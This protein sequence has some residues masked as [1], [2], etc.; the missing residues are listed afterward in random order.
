V[1]PETVYA[2]YSNKGGLL[3]A[4]V[5]GAVLRDDEPEK[6]LERR[7]VRRLL[8]QPDLRARLRSLVRHTAGTL[9]RTSPLC[10]VIRE[11][12][13][14]SSELADLNERLRELRFGGQAEIIAAI[15]KDDSLRPGLTIEEAADTFSALASPELHHLLTVGRGWSQRRYERWLERTTIAALVSG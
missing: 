13:T 10:E 7:W 9:E 5:R 15:A 8:Q 3:E 4:V 11:A 12:G 1:A 6:V 14:G 2:V